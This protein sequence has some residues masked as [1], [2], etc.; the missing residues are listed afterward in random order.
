MK[1]RFTLLMSMLYVLIAFAQ[2]PK[3]GVV[4]I[5]SV[6]QSF[7]EIKIINQQLDSIKIATDSVFKPLNTQMKEK[8]FILKFVSPSDTLKI[9][10]LIDDIKLIYQELELIQQKALRAEN[11]VYQ[12]GQPYID[13]INESVKKLA[14]KKNLTFVI[15]KQHISVFPPKGMIFFIDN[16]LFYWDNPLFYSGEAIDITSVLIEEFNPS[17]PKQK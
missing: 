6:L 5:D 9:K 4:D 13:K 16:P 14:E 8:N 15:P 10:T 3:Y 12:K 11:S 1:K 17:K 2:T 7:P